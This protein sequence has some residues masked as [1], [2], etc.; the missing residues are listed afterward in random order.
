MGEL[1]A[2]RAPLVQHCGSY[3]FCNTVVYRALSWVAV[4]VLGVLYS[5]EALRL[6]M[7]SSHLETCTDRTA[8]DL[9]PRVQQIWNREE[10]TH[11]MGLRE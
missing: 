5:T 3:G 11:T 2:L 10:F 4:C 9:E 1:P 6:V 8:T 7:T